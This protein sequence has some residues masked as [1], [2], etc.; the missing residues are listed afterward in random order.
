M[1]RRVKLAFF[2][3]IAIVLEK[4]RSKFEKSCFSPQTVKAILQN[5]LFYLTILLSFVIG[6]WGNNQVV[7]SQT[8]MTLSLSSPAFA[9]QS[10][11][12]TSYTCQ[13]R[14]ISPPLTWSGIP[15]GTKSLVL[16]V[17]DPDAPDPAAPKLTW[18]HWILYN[19]PPSLTSLPEGI[20]L[21]NLPN[22][23]GVGLNNWNRRDY[24]GPCPPI[25]V[26]RYFHKLFALDSILR[27]ADSPTK[28]D[29]EAAMSGH[30]LE[31]AEL[32]GTYKKRSESS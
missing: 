11:I 15:E 29:V 10:E 7:F 13:G 18:V 8:A 31:Q 2:V 20:S 26:H 25:G 32:M 9:H 21:E 19:L 24:G 23:T 22:G 27:I 1:F 5:L 30:V 17:D 3:L 12:P 4:K 16:I 28:A 6:V 14:D